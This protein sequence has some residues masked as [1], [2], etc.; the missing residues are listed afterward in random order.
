[1]PDTPNQPEP[2]EQQLHDAANTIPDTEATPGSLR[3]QIVAALMRV[4]SCYQPTE[5][6]HWQADAVLRVVDPLLRERD[7]ALSELTRWQ[8]M[9]GSVDT[10]Q[11]LL[12]GREAIAAELRDRAERAEAEVRHH[13]DAGQRDDEKITALTAERAA[14]WHL[15]RKQTRQ[16]RIWRRRANTA[17]TEAVEQTVRDMQRAGQLRRERDEARAETPPPGSLVRIT[18]SKQGKYINS[19]RWVEVTVGDDGRYTHEE[20]VHAGNA[21]VEVIQQP[22]PELVDVDPDLI[23]ALRGLGNDYGS[24]GVALA[25]ARLT[26]TTVLVHQL[27]NGKPEPTEQPSPG[28]RSW[29][30]RLSPDRREIAIWEP[31]NE[32]WFIPEPGMSGRFV[33]DHDVKDWTPFRPA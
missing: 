31:G 21:T 19:G 24:L 6:H 3:E 26:D 5:M 8:S 22:A 9:F 27:T 25:A 30:F 33:S 17:I 2:W 10:A 11:A 16:M 4:E 15:L 28:E 14:L 29:E 23:D 1:M 20:D 13:I 7:E 32:P 18:W 12:D